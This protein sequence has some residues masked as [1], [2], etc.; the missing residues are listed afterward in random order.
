MPKSRAYLRALRKKHGL[1]EFAS[2][3]KSKR[4]KSTY[5]KPRRTVRRRR[6]A[7]VGAFTQ[8]SL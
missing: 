3:R 2:R 4:R 1:G 6:S 8:F 7:K 5:T